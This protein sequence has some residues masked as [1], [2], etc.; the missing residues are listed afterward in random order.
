VGI[1]DRVKQLFGGPGLRRG[2]RHPEVL[3]P[4]AGASVSAHLIKL[5]REGRVQR[6]PGD[7]PLAARWHVLVS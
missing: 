7:D 3:Y 2:R 4:A 1:L 5:E 6:T